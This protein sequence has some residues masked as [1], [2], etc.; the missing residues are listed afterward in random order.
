MKKLH[1]I[2]NVSLCFSA[3]L[4]LCITAMAFQDSTKIRR[5]ESKVI[6][7]TIPKKNTVEININSVDLEKTI[8]ESLALA[9]ESI[10]KIDWDKVS[11][12]IN[13]SIKNI[14]LDKMK[15]DVD[16]AV[17]S[18][19]VDKIKNEINLS[20]KEID[21]AKFK[22][23]IQ[24]EVRDAIKNINTE[25]LKNNIQKINKKDADKIKRDIEKL[26]ED[27][28]KS[29]KEMKN[30]TEISSEIEEKQSSYKSEGL[31]YKI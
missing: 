16:N 4:I 20:L 12:Q 5:K 24:K 9:E 3:V 18:I 10:K 11:N 6:L 25:Q 26:Q 14:D 30:T 28:E 8:R 21:K 13:Q 1:S 23:D 7:D 17:K 19:D 2:K 29:K 31:F 22:T 15:I 27:L